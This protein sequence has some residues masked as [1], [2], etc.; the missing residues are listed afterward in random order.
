M[1]EKIMKIHTPEIGK[2]YITNQKTLICKIK[3]SKNISISINLYPQYFLKIANK[4]S[5]QK[6]FCINKYELKDSLNDVKLAL[7]KNNIIFEN[8]RRLQNK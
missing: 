6:L 7:R 8:I 5:D 3:I 1:I 2:S 4:K